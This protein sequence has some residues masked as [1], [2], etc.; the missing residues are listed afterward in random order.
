MTITY[1]DW[2]IPPIPELYGIVELIPE[3]YGIMELIPEL[4]GI[5]ELYHLNFCAYEILSI[6][7]LNFSR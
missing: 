4:Y 6:G 5:M 7:A 1:Y 3:L 2:V